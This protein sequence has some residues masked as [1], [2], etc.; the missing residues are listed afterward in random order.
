MKHLSVLG[1]LAMLSVLA[2]CNGKGGNDN[3]PAVGKTAGM[4]DNKN[5]D[6][7]E[8]LQANR[9]V[10]TAIETGNEETLRKYI[11]ADA[12]DRNGGPN[13]KEIKG[14][15]IIKVLSSFHNDVDNMKMEIISQATDGDYIFTL[16]RATGTT[17]KPWMGMPANFKLDSKSVDVVRVKDKKMVEHWQ[18]MDPAEMMKMGG[19]AAGG[20]KKQR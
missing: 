14:E 11:S 7:Q 13:G 12:V 2:G 5:N 4:S 3:S 16:V 20:D 9:E 6:Q 19:M 18:Y 15:E 1:L 8:M 17:K 10:Y